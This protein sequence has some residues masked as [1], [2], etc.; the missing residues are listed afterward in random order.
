MCFML[1]L[2]EDYVTALGDASQYVIGH[3]IAHPLLGLLDASISVQGNA[4]S[5][6]L[7]QVALAR[8]MHALAL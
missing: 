3:A 6:P 7:D 1:A 4:I 5:A 8:P 2:Y